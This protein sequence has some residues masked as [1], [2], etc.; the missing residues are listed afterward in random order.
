MRRRADPVDLLRRAL[1]MCGE[2]RL[3][4]TGDSMLPTLLPGGTVRVVRVP[5][6]QVREGDVVA[7]TM[8][9]AVLVHRVAHRQAGRLVTRGDNMPLLDPATDAQAFLGVVPGLPP[10]PPSVPPPAVVGPVQVHLWLIGGGGIDVPP[11]WVVRWVSHRGAG[12]DA[13]ALLAVATGIRAGTS[14][15]ISPYGVTAIDDL[16]PPI[17]PTHLVVGGA[18]GGS[19]PGGNQLLPPALVHRHVRPGLPGEAVGVRDTV[20]ALARVL[21]PMEA[22]L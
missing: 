1:E 10:A 22:A 7:V 16:G 6:E 17:G 3:A 5:Y 14:I 19:L 2:A 21:A 4:V 20:A 12:V 8:D 18:F 9:G 13:A 11:N 15:G